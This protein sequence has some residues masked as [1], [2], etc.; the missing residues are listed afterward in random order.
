VYGGGLYK[1]EPKELANVP[2][3]PIMAMLPATE[4]QPI[5]QAEMFKELAA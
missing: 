5:T 1:M 4:R 2:A 3:E